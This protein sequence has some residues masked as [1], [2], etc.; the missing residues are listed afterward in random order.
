MRDRS[1]AMRA[2]DAARAA[3]T[4]ASCDGRPGARDR[5]RSAAGVARVTRWA[6]LAALLAALAAGA[7]PAVAFNT[8]SPHAPNRVTYYDA[9]GK[10][11]REVRRAAAAWNSS[12]ARVRW[13]R[14]PRSRARVIVTI[15]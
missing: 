11:G 7:A 9:T 8:M 5:P 1:Q 4:R 14:A 15:N 6:F 13:V 2:L 12:G 10:Y 3:M